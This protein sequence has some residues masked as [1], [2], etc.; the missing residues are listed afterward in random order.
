MKNDA[1]KHPKWEPKSDQ[2]LKIS[3]KKDIKKMMQK[4]DAKKKLNPRISADFRGFWFDFWG[5]AGG[6]GDH[7]GDKGFTSK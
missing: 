1:K 3:G 2:K 4:F 7:K 6:R 5:V